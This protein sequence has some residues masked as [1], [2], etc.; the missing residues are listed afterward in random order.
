IQYGVLSTSSDSHHISSTL[1]FVTSR[2]I[3]NLSCSVRFF[4]QA[5][6]RHTH[7]CVSG[8]WAR[9]PC[10]GDS[11]GPLVT[12]GIRGKPILIGLTSFGTK[13][14]CQL[15]WPSV[16]TRIT[17]YLDWIGESAGKLMKP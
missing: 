7:L 15:S 17:S 10:Q 13:G 14:G 11:G 16:F 4:L 6:I 5:I 3:S 12:T 9:G 1:L 8:R 2:G